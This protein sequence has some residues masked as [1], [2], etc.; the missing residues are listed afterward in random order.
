M[1][2]WRHATFL[3]DDTRH[4]TGKDGKGDNRDWCVGKFG[5]KPGL[6]LKS[7][8][9]GCGTAIKLCHAGPRSQ[10]LPE[11]KSL[12][13]GPAS[14]IHQKKNWTERHSRSAMCGGKAAVSAIHVGRTL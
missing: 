2:T 8:V 14:H 5:Q 4:E 9:D 6:L 10:S 13:R 3:C 12:V 1:A 7:E 11:T